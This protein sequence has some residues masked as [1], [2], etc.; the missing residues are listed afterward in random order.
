MNNYNQTYIQLQPPP[1]TSTNYEAIFPDN[2][3]NYHVS[4]SSSSSVAAA[5][6]TT[7]SAQQFLPNNVQHH[8]EIGYNIDAT[9]DN[10]QVC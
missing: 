5:T 6:T 8:A 9:T 1:P 3:G 2:V 10:I 4:S 7:N